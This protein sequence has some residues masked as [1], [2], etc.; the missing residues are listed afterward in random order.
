MLENVLRDAPLLPSLGQLMDSL[1]GD[2]MDG[3]VSALSR[4]WPDEQEAGLRA[5]LRLLVD[6]RTWRLLRD[7]GLGDAAAADLGAAMVVGAAG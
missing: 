1:W 6:F 2:Y 4:G 3:L 7:S 5:A